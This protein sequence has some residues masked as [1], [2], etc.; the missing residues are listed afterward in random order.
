MPLTDAEKRV[1]RQLL[2]GDAPDIAVLRSQVDHAWVVRTW[3]DGLPSVDIEIDPGVPRARAIDDGPLSPPGV[4]FDDDWVPIGHLM[5][6][7]EN[8]ALSALEYAWFSDVAPKQ[9][10][11]NDHLRLEDENRRYSGPMP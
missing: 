10:P 5:I 3:I 2:V 8:G 7:V 1:I 9:L 11:D 4:A 6:W